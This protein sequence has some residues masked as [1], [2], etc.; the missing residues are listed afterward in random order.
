MPL[1][2]PAAGAALWSLFDAGGPRPEYVLPM[3]YAES[4][5][6][7][8]VQN[9]GGSANY[10]VNQASTELIASY[11]NVDPS[12]YVTWSASQQIDTVVRGMLLDLVHRFGPLKSG[13]RV[14]QANFLPATLP[15]VT[16]LD[17]VLARFGDSAYSGNADLDTQHKGTITLGDLANFVGR[18]VRGATV[19]SAL[20]QTYELRPGVAMRDPVMGEDF[21]SGGGS[22]LGTLSAAAGFGL[23]VYALLRG[24]G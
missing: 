6:D 22:T 15:S 4:G 20:Q 18:N 11:A 16:T 17:G 19:Q 3:L 2:F 24:A 23:L 9:R 10:G 8:S 7:P 21:L 14:E 5:F 1:D 13:A 12:T